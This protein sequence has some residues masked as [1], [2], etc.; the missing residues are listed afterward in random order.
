[1]PQKASSH[2]LPCLPLFLGVA[3]YLL[4]LPWMELRGSDE[5]VFASIAREMVETGRYFQPAF[6]GQPAQV[7]PLY[8]WLVCLCAGFQTPGLLAV[9][10]PAVL[11]VFGMAAQ[12][13]WVGRRH[14]D[15]RTGALAAAIVLTTFG[16]FRVG[17][18]GQA[19]TLHA[20]L[21]SGAW[22][23][24]HGL[25]A[26][27][28]RWRLAWAV[29]LGLVFLDVLC[30]GLRATLLFYLPLLLTRMPPRTRRL[31]RARE[32]LECLC[33]FALALY[34]WFTLV[35]P[36]PLTG[37]SALV[38]P[39][40]SSA[41]PEGFFS[42]LLHFPLRCLRDLMPWSL[43]LWIP[44]CLALKP[45][46]PAGSLCGFL[47]ATILTLFLL[48]WFMPGYS[49]LMMLPVLPGLAAMISFNLPIVMHRQ[50]RGWKRINRALSWGTLLILLYCAL[51]WMWVGLGRITFQGASLSTGV[52]A[53]GWCVALLSLLLGGW[54]WLQGRQPT[55]EG[56][57]WLTLGVRLAWIALV[58][59]PSF[60]T[61]G[62]RQYAA[63]KLLGQ[64]PREE[65][66]LEG[67]AVRVPPGEP[68]YLLPRQKAFPAQMFYMDHRVLRL[69]KGEPLPGK[70]LYL[71]AG[72]QPLFPGWR[73]KKLS[74][75]VDFQMHRKLEPSPL[76][77][78]G[79]MLLPNFPGRHYVRRELTPQEF[80]PHALEYY[81]PLWMNLYQGDPEPM[82]W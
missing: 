26:L 14:R 71:I 13:F 74:G 40:S 42:H 35:C 73:W 70:P 60:L 8:P 29:S 3:L 22:L 6:Q 4:C 17:I 19:E 49:S 9:R 62:D 7:F 54:V 52:P 64:I 38:G 77:L 50:E 68:L 27:G 18:Y 61:M 2:F 23:A 46:E 21:L 72:R 37:W 31:L 34:L 39:L 32:H 5:A 12:A 10:L 69:R 82:D 63:R 57:A 59:L 53:L 55:G 65:G 81:E 41:V 15:T 36:Q 76:L 33:V 75:P 28:R 78:D 24:W 47:R 51:H 58:V 43:F 67:E 80:P 30:A 11:A 48:H 16:A 66:P 56:V 25:G 45:L 1:M 44:F 79:K 20:C